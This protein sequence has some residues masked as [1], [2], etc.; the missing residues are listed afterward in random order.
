MRKV[1][2]NYYAGKRDEY[3]VDLKK[4]LTNYRKSGKRIK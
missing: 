4:V 2:S 3:D 1:E